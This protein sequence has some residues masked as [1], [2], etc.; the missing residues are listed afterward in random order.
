[1]WP[2]LRRWSFARIV[3]GGALAALEARGNADVVPA[4]IQ[5]LR[6]VGDGS[7]INAT[8][9]ALTGAN[10]IDTWHDWILW[11]EAHPE[12]EAFG[13]F[14]AFKADAMAL[15]DP[16]FRLGPASPTTFASKRLYGAALPRTASRR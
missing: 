10:G 16:N 15:I 4:L 14:D 3:R 9:R 2:S 5:A 6:F 13:G 11:Q 12:I 8:L 7:D 1:M